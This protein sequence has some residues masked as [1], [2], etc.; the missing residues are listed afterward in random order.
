MALFGR[1]D[2]K[3]WVSLLE[4]ARTSGEAGN[5]KDAEA[6]LRSAL[7]MRDAVS[8][9]MFSDLVGVANSLAADYSESAAGTV[10]ASL[11]AEA[12]TDPQQVA[13][14]RRELR[15]TQE[16]L[17]RGDL[18]SAQQTLQRSVALAK[19]IPEVL[20]S[21]ESA[22][23][24]VSLIEAC[25]RSFQ[26]GDQEPALTVIR[27]ACVQ[28]SQLPDQAVNQLSTSLTRL[29]NDERRPDPHQEE[30]EPRRFRERF[31][32][33]QRILQESFSG[34]LRSA[35]TAELQEWLG[36]RLHHAVQS[37]KYAEISRLL[38]MGSATEGALRGLEE[39]AA[40]ESVGVDL[41]IAG[42]SVQLWR[43]EPRATVRELQMTR[44]SAQ[45]AGAS[46]P[47]LVVA[48]MRM[49]GQTYVVCGEDSYNQSGTLARGLVAIA[50]NE[51]ASRRRANRLLAD[52]RLYPA[53]VDLAE[54]WRS[55]VSVARI[56]SFV[57]AQPGSN[58]RDP[59]KKELSQA[60]AALQ[61]AKPVPGSR[62]F[63]GIANDLEQQLQRGADLD[64]ATRQVLQQFLAITPIG[65]G[66]WGQFKAIIKTLEARCDGMPEEYGIAVARL[67]TLR[68]ATARPSHLL[69]ELTGLDP[70]EP[71]A[72]Q[73]TLNYLTR[74]ARR[75]LRRLSWQQ[76]D[77]YARVVMAF[78]S[79]VD[80]H[81][82]AGKPVQ[83]RQALDYVLYGRAHADRPKTRFP[84]APELPDRHRRRWDPAPQV[85]D[86]HLDGLENLVAGVRADVDIATWGVHVL[87]DRDREAPDIPPQLA[88][89]SADKQ[90]EQRGLL[91]LRLDHT[92]ARGLK[93]AAIATLLVRSQ[94]LD[95][96][97]VLAD[98][99]ARSGV[100]AAIEL[101]LS[102]P[103]RLQHLEVGEGVQRRMAQLALDTHGPALPGAILAKVLELTV[104]G[105]P[106]RDF[107][108]MASGLTLN[109]LAALRN[110][111]AFVAPAAVVG[112][113]DD[114][115]I[116]KAEGYSS[117][118]YTY[119]EEWTSSHVPD[120][121]LLGW[122]V[123]DLYA[124]DAPSFI[125]FL[126]RS[127]TDG[128]QIGR[129]IAA[130]CGIGRSDRIRQAL[131]WW[132]EV[133]T[134][135]EWSDSLGA[136]DTSLAQ[137][138]LITQQWW[139][140]LSEGQ[141]A[142]ARARL[143]QIRAIGSSLLRATDSEAL[144]QFDDAQ[145]DT[146]WVFLAEDPERFRTD[147]SFAVAVTLVPD[148]SLCRT[149]VS[150]LQRQNRIKEVWLPLIE[151]GMPP[152]VAAGEH[153][154]G[155]VT[156]QPLLRDAVLSLIDSASP[157][158]R[159]V[160]LRLLENNDAGLTWADVLNQL[161]EHPEPG[162]WREVAARADDVSDP[163]RLQSFDH[164]VLATRRR[165]RAAKTLVQDRIDRQ[166][167]DSAS[168]DL[169]ML[170]TMANGTVTRDRE[171]ALA[172]LLRRAE[173]G[174]PVPGLHLE[175]E[176]EG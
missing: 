161:T 54:A 51:E 14:W 86:A 90:L 79:G 145:L 168:P 106:G 63:Q 151:S 144:V 146:L 99:R 164:V 10:F 133:A 24:W 104:L 154:L 84:K 138:A 124:W 110:H 55:D 40:W 115:I 156:S 116:A 11:A 20:V 33:L 47:D 125:G 42:D 171:W 37:R 45:H 8:E 105:H 25:E 162:L 43:P 107:S 127:R 36:V 34:D 94:P 81:Q 83:R 30:Q 23:I 131:E 150:I 4:R 111:V 75:V 60:G 140:L 12:E 19:T 41:E 148:A 70:N 61:G 7:E 165:G 175:V 170:L 46:L 2:R 160:G 126:A 82:S 100:S 137:H 143:R 18:V 73:K 66:V 135:Q 1:R 176:E 48:I 88:L 87:R 101:L 3:L 130:I 112:W 118:L 122:H 53:L 119:A 123:A 149:A 16:A 5:P 29:A 152:A 96:A 62:A 120:L 64:P 167:P 50:G 32:Q 28:G 26:T 163:D 147:D 102:H 39:L 6:A 56:R 74:R 113:L 166:S 142:A 76:P 121:Q 114:L 172:Q 158:A 159:K 136:I 129:S 21:A 58:V 128:Q 95:L 69:V 108:A 15:E 35:E 91:S 139:E 9:A 52:R 77:T 72:G 49:A 169:E 132:S 38:V 57:T 13:L 31:F 71:V 59:S 155:Q 173:S 103:E 44:Q 109:D 141:P 134:D 98:P 17:Q 89:L 67:T 117:S 78:L 27:R 157:P 80:E 93:P 65:D 153:Y 68:P 85:W 22:P 97:E 92:T 174:Q